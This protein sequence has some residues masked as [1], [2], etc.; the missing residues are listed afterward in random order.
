MKAQILSI[1][2]LYKAIAWS[3]P[4]PK[5]PKPKKVPPPKKATSRLGVHKETRSVIQGG[6]AVTRTVLAGPT[7]PPTEAK[8]A[9]HVAKP[10]SGDTHQ[11]SPNH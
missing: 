3:T 9:G 7:K 4:M 1:D 6:K 8:I 5:V 10:T 2:E 11:H